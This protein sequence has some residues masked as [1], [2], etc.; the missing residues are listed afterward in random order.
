MPEEGPPA[1]RRRDD[2]KSGFWLS[3]TRIARA[4]DG[5]PREDWKGGLFTVAA[6]LARRRNG[7]NQNVRVDRWS[8]QEPQW[9]SI[10]ANTLAPATR[11]NLAWVADLYDLRGA[12]G[13]TLVVDFADWHVGGG[14]FTT[15]AIGVS[16][17]LVA[18]SAEYAE[19]TS[20]SRRQTIYYW[21]ATA[22]QGDP[23][24]YP[25]ETPTN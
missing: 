17:Q 19:C 25:N 13:A 2:P 9:H 20:Q 7:L 23:R 5:K 1:K 21:P 6:K 8:L 3:R 22:S 24:N 15:N 4:L 11:A 14:R 16:G 10:Q 18:Q 12:T